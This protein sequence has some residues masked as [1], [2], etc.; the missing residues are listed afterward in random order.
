MIRRSAFRVALAGLLVGLAVLP[1]DGRAAAADIDGAGP[2]AV[3]AIVGNG[4]VGELGEAA[5]VLHDYGAASLVRTSAMPAPPVASRLHALPDDGEVSFRSW[6]GRVDL[7]EALPESRHGTWVIRLVGPLD[8]RW[9]AGFGAAGIEILAHAHPHAL[10]VRADRNAVERSLA[11]VTTEG[12]PVVAGLALLP[13]EARLHRSLSLATADRGGR[14]PTDV[15]AYAWDGRPMP[16]DTKHALA[17]GGLEAVLADHPEI[18]YLE[19]AF[20]KDLHNNLAARWELLGV[21]EAWHLDVVGDGVTVLHNDSG[22]DLEHPGL[23]GSIAA[24]VG[25]MEYLDTAHG[26]HTAGSIVGGPPDP[27]PSNTAGCGDVIPGLPTAGGMAPGAT[28][29]TNNIFDGGLAEIPEMM[30]WGAAHGALLSNNSWGQVDGS[31]PVAG[32]TLASAQ[33]DAAVRD[34]DPGV[35]GAQPMVLFFSAGNTGPDPGTVTAPATGKNVIAVGAVQ[36]AR[37]GAWVPS[38]QPGPDPDRVV[39]TSGRGPSQLR[40]KPDLV[41]PGSDVLSLESRDGYAVQ[42]W[43]RDWTGRIFALNT[44]TSQACALATGA[45]ALLHEVLWRHGRTGLRPSPALLKAVLIATADRAGDAVDLDRG[46]GRIALSPLPTTALPIVTF[47]QGET[48]ELTTGGSWS[49][50]IAV[51]SGDRPLELA[52]VWTD[53]PGQADADH[54]LVNDLDLVVTSPSGTVLRGNVVEGGWS[55][56]DPGELRDRDNNVEVVRVEHPQAG[57]W[58]V[59]VVAV[60]AALPPAGLDGQDFAIAAAGDVGACLDQPQPPAAV[61]AAPA[62]DNAIVVTWSPVS[63][64]SRYEVARATRSGGRPYEVV[65]TVDGGVTSFTDDGLSGGTT[66]YYVVRAEVDCWSADSYEV[67]ATAIGPCT[68][69]PVFAGIASVTGVHGTSCSLELAWAPATATCPAPVTYDIY[70]G[71]TPGFEPS[72]ANRIAEGLTAQTWLDRGLEPDREVFYLTRASHAGSGED[73]GNSARLG[74]RPAGPDEAYLDPI[75]AEFLHTW[76]RV[77]GSTADPGTEPWHRTDDDAWDGLRSWF[78]QDEP[79]LKD[80]V[81]E[82]REPIPLV[83]GEPP[84]LEFHHRMRLDRG[85]DGGRLEYSTNGG[86]DWF[87]ILSGDGQTVPDAPDRFLAGGYTDTIAAPANPLVLADAWSGDTAGWVRTVVDMADFAG[88]RILLR[89]RFACDDTPGGSWGWWVDGIRLVVARECQGCLPPD[90]PP[91][92]WS[93]ATGAGVELSWPEAPGAATYRVFRSTRLASPEQEIATV[94]APQTSYLDSQVSGGTTYYYQVRSDDGCVSDP[95]IVTTVTA[96]GPCTRAPEFWGLDEVVD[97]REAG[98]ALDLVWRPA[99]PGCDGADVRYR[100]YRSP[101][102]GF[103]PGPEVLIADGVAGPRYRDT[104]VADRETWFYRVRAVDGISGAEDANP[105]ERGGWTTGPDV[106]LFADSVEGGASG[107]LTGPGSGQDSGT[108]P[109]RV[110]DE[111]AFRGDRSWFCADEAVVKDQVVELEQPVSVD[112]PNTV[113]AFYHLFDHEV[114]WDGGR[115]EYSS[116]GGA[117]WHDILDGDGATVP[118]NPGRFLLGGYTGTLSFGTGNPLAG[119]RAWT[120]FVS[121]W[122]ETVVDLADFAGLDLRLRWRLVC[123]ASEAETGWW[124]DDVE[125]WLTSSCTATTLSGPRAGGGRRPF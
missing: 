110:V 27:A 8:A 60:D 34:A 61:Q 22:V 78:V 64:A 93:T 9:R 91:W 71:S 17:S 1:S 70:R 25:R 98:C 117:T 14:G 32:Y 52:L 66:Y 86:R 105:V 74:G 44:G 68:N 72:D 84:R 83:A 59:E 6:R 108:E 124:L 20:G 56:P 122:L 2:T 19:P 87:D 65:A 13:A 51:R 113:L 95:S 35:D 94:A 62:G 15:R 49:T 30:A 114:F 5:T 116:D 112:D 102:A 76:D 39:T 31:A 73:D 75:T 50:E 109:W 12:V 100:V 28:L 53:P 24:S 23:A 77:P 42:H 48:A 120:G 99:E 115:L 41:A 3:L 11:V 118:A 37:C 90:P 54:P 46:W 107:W 106:L 45:G 82:L 92:L 16:V 96:T 104:T 103:V 55:R 40:V 111:L 10:V 36:N 67:S 18:G 26:T 33:A 47:D 121:G 119:E 4:R 63:G 97:R 81:L 69:V 58:S 43:D 123:D 29:V 125:L 7:P 57:S 85:R 89:W 101:A 79:R 80:Q 88:L 21:E 38:R